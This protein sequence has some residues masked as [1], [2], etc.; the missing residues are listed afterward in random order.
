M[1]ISA[2]NSV[3]NLSNKSIQNNQLYKSVSFSGFEDED[4]IDFNAMANAVNND[5]P[6]SKKNAP[7]K[8]FLTSAFLALASLFAAKKVS[9]VALKTIETKLSLAKPMGNLGQ[10]ISKGLDRLKAKQPV[11]VVGVKTFFVNNTNKALNW[12][13]TSIE[14]I[15]KKGVTAED[16]AAFKK[17]MGGKVTDGA[18]YANNALRK[19]IASVLGLGSAGATIVSRYKDENGNGIPDKVEKTCGKLEGASEIVKTVASICEAA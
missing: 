12:L 6:E 18:L 16:L 13:G 5:Q 8:F 7:V 14:N 4:S 1:Q 2:I 11:E 10:K 19:G 9:T 17:M 3:N 15:G